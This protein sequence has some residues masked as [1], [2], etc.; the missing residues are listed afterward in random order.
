MK[1]RSD[2]V[3][4]S[5]E[6]PQRSALRRSKGRSPGR[7][8]SCAFLSAGILALLCA[9]AG[10]Q[11][12]AGVA[13]GSV[14][15]PCGGIGAGRPR[16]TAS[17]DAL[18]SLTSGANGGDAASAS[19]A[20]GPGGTSSGGTAEQK[21]VAQYRPITPSISVTETLTNNVNLKP[22]SQAQSDLVSLIT[23]ELAIDERG[24]RTCLRGTI[25]APATLY[26]KTGGENNKI[27]P[28]AS[29]LGHAEVLEQLFFIDG[30]IQVS[31]QFLTPFGAQPVD[32]SNATQNR[33]TAANYRISPYIKGVTT[34]GT[35]YEVRNNN[36]WTNL[37]GAPIATSNAYYNEWLAHVASPDAR[38]GWSL[39]YDWNDVKFNNQPPLITE[40]TRGTVFYQVD[41]NVRVSAD[42]GYE[43]NRYTFTDY[44][45][46]IYGVGVRWRPTPRTNPSRT[47][48]I[49]F[50]ARRIS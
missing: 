7:R 23:P 39:D 12:A 24:T 47:G 6:C 26:V 36:T 28:S 22:S 42:G 38:T 35:R 50:S 31:Q 3:A 41:P 34:D 43:D 49:G 29:L 37:S 16:N 32:L 30:S 44:R 33:Y 19:S 11:Y 10:A 13:T 40:L 46:A 18:S 5:P 14:G 45:D 9:P 15:D 20:G 27:Y 1:T 25:A 21:T 8:R 17:T 48:S 2:P 4:S